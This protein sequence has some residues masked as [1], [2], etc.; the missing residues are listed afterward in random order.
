VPEKF[1]EQALHEFDKWSEEYDKPGF[2]QRHLFIPTEDHIIKELESLEQPDSKFSLLDVGCGTGKLIVRLRKKFPHASF[3]GMD[4]A[5]GMISVAKQKTAGMENIEFRVADASERF[6]YPDKSFH[7]VTCSHSFHHYPNQGRTVREFHRVLKP[8]GKL[9]LV[10]SDIN[11]L[12]GKV[13]HQVI[14][15]T[16]ERFRVHHFSAISLMMFLEERG[17]LVIR[18]D[19]RGDWVPWMM[20]VAVAQK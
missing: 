18:Q 6:P 16:Y 7:Y 10:D 2:F 9:L 1:K 12:W 4:I 15:G 8:G 3:Q 19:R 20:T 11:C 13:M 17:F 14:I 5:P